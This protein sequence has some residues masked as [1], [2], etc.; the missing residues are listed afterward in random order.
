[1]DYF[2]KAILSALQLILQF[3]PEIYQIAWTSI[4]ISLIATVFASFFW[5]FF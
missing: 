2:S 3:D 4:K 5:H 1:M